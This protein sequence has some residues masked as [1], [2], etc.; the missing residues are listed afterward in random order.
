VS[1]VHAGH[2]KAPTGT[3]LLS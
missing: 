2:L 3:D 1:G